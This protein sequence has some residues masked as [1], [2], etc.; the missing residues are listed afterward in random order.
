MRIENFKSEVRDDKSRLAASVVWEDSD[1]PTLDVFYE[2]AVESAR[3]LCCNPHAFLIAAFL[4]AW[5]SG[6]RR[7]SVTGKVCPELRQGL[8]TVTGVIG[9]WYK[10]GPHRVSKLH[11]APS[12]ESPGSREQ[13]SSFQGGSIHWPPCGTITSV[14][15]RG[16]RGGFRMDCWSLD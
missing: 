8:E 12:R 7:V 1:R 2:T 15:R 3:G 14:F 13:V 6:E 9:H 16:V 10:K 4:S 5:R 11:G